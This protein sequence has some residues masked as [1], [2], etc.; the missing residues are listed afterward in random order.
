[1]MAEAT[2]QVERE[3]SR[4]QEAISPIHDSYGRDH[5]NLTVVK[6]YLRKPII[7]DRAARCFEQHRPESLIEFPSEAA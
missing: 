7:N 4:L 3:P 1:M 2:A 6:E 5:L